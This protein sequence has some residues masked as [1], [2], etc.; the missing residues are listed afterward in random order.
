[1][2]TLEER[3]SDTS[4]FP[5]LTGAEGVFDSNGAY[6]EKHASDSWSQF[7]EKAQTIF[8]DN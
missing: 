5:Q 6:H 4:R 2:S 7:L 3:L 8:S 1:M